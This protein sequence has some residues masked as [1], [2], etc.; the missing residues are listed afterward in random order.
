[1]EITARSKATESL[2]GSPQTNY[3]IIR[4][5]FAFFSSAESPPCGLQIT[6]FK[7]WSAHASHGHTDS[8]TDWPSDCRMD[9][10]CMT[11][12]LTYS[13]CLLSL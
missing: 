11:D 2:T 7:E 13:D 10:W 12:C 1:M 5:I 9:S 8:L 6:A 3:F 4:Y